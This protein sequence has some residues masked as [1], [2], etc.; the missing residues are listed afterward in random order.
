M[1]GA[2]SLKKIKMH[3]ASSVRRKGNFVFESILQIYPKRQIIIFHLASGDR[4]S[5]KSHKKLSTPTGRAG[6]SCPKGL[7]NSSNEL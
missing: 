2:A 6:R 4:T 3:S 1:H 7:K 5:K